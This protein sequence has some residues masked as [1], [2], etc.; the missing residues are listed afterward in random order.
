MSLLRVR[1]PRWGLRIALVAVAV[2]VAAH[3][4]RGDLGTWRPPDVEGPVIGTV[5]GRPHLADGDSLAF[6]DRRIRLVGIDAPELDQDCTVGGNRRP[7]GL[8]A[9]D[10]LAQLIAGREV[11]CAW[12]RF[13]KFG[14]GLARCRVG[15]TDL[16]AAL[17]RDGWAVAFGGYAGE[18]AEARAAGRGLWAGTFVWPQDFR[19]RKAI[20]GTGGAGRF[21][22]PEDDP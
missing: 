22:D 12:T 1:S 3:W 20:H 14:R 8:E 11:T 9:R 2:T 7:C 10:R 17:V 18:E 19:R 13:D 15:G 5:T 6:G 16:G 4:W 21:A